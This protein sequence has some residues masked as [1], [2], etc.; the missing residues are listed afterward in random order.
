MRKLAEHAAVP[1]VP[2]PGVGVP[3]SASL[4]LDPRDEQARG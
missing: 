4:D 2:G 1:E 3:V